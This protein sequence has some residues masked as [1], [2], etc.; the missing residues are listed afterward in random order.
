MEA[1]KLVTLRFMFEAQVGDAIDAGLRP[2]DFFIKQESSDWL[3]Q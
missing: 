2:R 3:S 1:I